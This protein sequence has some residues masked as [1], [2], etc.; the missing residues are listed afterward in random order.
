[1]SLEWLWRGYDPEKTQDVY[2]M[3]PEEKK[4]PMMRFTRTYPWINEYRVYESYQLDNRWVVMMMPT[5]W[6]YELIEAWYPNTAWNLY[7][8]GISMFNSYEMN[9]GRTT[10]AEIGGCYYAARLAVNE[11]LNE[12]RRQAGVVILREAHPGYILPVGVWNVRENVRA[13]LKN[14]PRKFGTLNETL[15]FI[16]TKLEIP[17]ERW[18]KNSGVLKHRLYQRK[19][20]DFFSVSHTMGG[21]NE[22]HRD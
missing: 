1:M 6:C 17:M 15:K 5:E 7:G 13:A 14:R 3:D 21:E 16:S 8:K 10:Y 9:K 22:N 18:I 19:L 4:L 12:E 20:E 2:L 11:K